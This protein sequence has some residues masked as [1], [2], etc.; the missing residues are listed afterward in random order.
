MKRLIRTYLP[1]IIAML[2]LAGAAWCVVG[3][4]QTLV[5]EAG[6]PLDRCIENG[7]VFSR[8]HPAFQACLKNMAELFIKLDYTECKDLAKSF[9]TLMSA[10]LVASITF[11]EKIVNVHAAGKGPLLAMVSCWVLLLSALLAC[12]VG[13]AMISL[14]AGNAAYVPHL[15][16]RVLEGAAAMLFVLAGL[17]F[18]ASLVALFVS[19]VLSIAEKRAHAQRQSATSTLPG[20]ARP[21]LAG[22]KPRRRGISRQPLG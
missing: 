20:R 14:A 1:I 9:L 12:G 4:L 18:A 3:W 19:G 6:K 16:Y 10:M 7:L 2:A 13:L 15:D 22:F 5:A 17:L 21:A 8:G 11:S